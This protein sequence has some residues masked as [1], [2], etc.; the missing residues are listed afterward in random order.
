MCCVYGLLTN[1]YLCFLPH[2][3]ERQALRK[4]Y[5][6]KEEPCDDFVVTLCCG[7]C[8]LCQEAREIKARGKL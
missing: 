6:L 2:Y 3:I 1:C 8:A 5:N 7:P 4:K